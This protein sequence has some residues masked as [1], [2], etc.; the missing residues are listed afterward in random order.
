MAGAALLAL[1]AACPA[2]SQVTGQEVRQSVAQ[3]IALLKSQQ[4][5][6][7]HWPAY[8]G[9]DGGTT[10][11][12][13]LALINAGL[14]LEDPAVQ[15]GVDALAKLKNEKTYVV[16]LK[17]QVLAAADPKGQKYRKPLQEAVNWLI[18]AQTKVGMWGY[19]QA[20][21]RGDNSNTQFALL[22]LH[23]AAKV[24][25]EVPEPIWRRSGLHFTNTQLPDGSWG[26]SYH[27][28]QKRLRNRRLN[29]YGS[30]TTAALASLYICGQELFVGGRKIL[31]NGA[32]P[33]CGKY[34][35]NIVLAKGLEWMTRNFSVK[36][37]PGR[38]QGWLYYYLYGL[39]RVG[40]ISGQRTFGPHDW[41]R[42]GA[43]FLV[44]NQNQRGWGRVRRRGVPDTAFALLF[45]AKGN[46]PVLFQKV[47]WSGQ[48]NPNAW[49]R[50]I[51]DLEN[52]TRH[53][54]DA[55]GRPVTWQSASLDLSLE[56]LRIS[57]ILFLAGHEFPQFT[58]AQKRKI[59]QFV[60]S[61]GTLLAEACCTSARFRVGFEAMA[62][63]L[64]PDY[65]LRPLPES[66]PVFGS[67]YDLEHQYDLQGIDIGCRTGV[68][69]SPRPLSV[70]WEMQDLVQNDQKLSE[71]AFRMGTNIAAYATGREQLANK[72]DEVILPRE[73][74]KRRRAEVP[75]GAVRI[76]R[77]YH[78]GDYNADPKAL[79]ELTG[80]LRDQAGVDVVTRE[81]QLLVTDD[82]IYEYPVVFMTGHYGFEM[83]QEEIEA[84]R[85]YLKRGGFLFADACCGRQDFDK[86]F[87]KMVSKLFPEAEFKKLDRDHPILTGKVGKRLGRMTY[88]KILAEEKAK[89]GDPDPTG[90]NY[91][92]VYAIVL[93]GRVVLAY[94]PYDFSCALEGDNPYSCR[95]YVDE[96]GRNLAMNLVLYAITY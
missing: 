57:P 27:V 84:L 21:G 60:D 50:N 96:D 38:G 49:N 79:T 52:L 12:A 1:F 48:L 73:D 69:F 62:K 67:F 44:A 14:G 31:V 94:S 70:L 22:G 4:Q 88:R 24:G 39:E 23:E 63:E 77:L 59:Q 2:W 85:A 16:S 72:L 25:I 95:G 46:R 55:F 18:Q 17:C 74:P 65:P 75:R 68:F 87:R 66:H 42:K 11:L 61:G 51:H 76:A 41:Y 56:Q 64:W 40:M 43:A 33:S 80:L 83:S 92:G 45:L 89:A 36:E 10:G 71:F 82:T 37:N 30:M 58:D 91:P 8:G 86:A 35:Q 20:Q 26:Y 53:V 78:K 54:S 13:T 9:Y 7:G 3:G 81:R 90:T 47:K 19:R 15:K 34:Q 28:G 6:D 29:G 32:W 93:D 5:G